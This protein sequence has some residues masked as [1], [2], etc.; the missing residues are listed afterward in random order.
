MGKERI[1]KR[2]K[3]MNEIQKKLDRQNRLY[4]ETVAKYLPKSKMTGQMS[5][6][7]WRRG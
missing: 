1:S 7:L 3:E 5:R 4:E 6:C 2:Q